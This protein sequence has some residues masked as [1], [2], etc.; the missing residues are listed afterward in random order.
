MNPLPPSSSRQDK[1]NPDVSFVLPC[2]NEEKALPFCIARINEARVVLEDSG[3]SSEIIIADN[4][5]TD[6]SIEIALEQGA[7]VQNI[8]EKG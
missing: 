6:K 4:G 3:L 8:R 2:L 5:S 1:R 7:R